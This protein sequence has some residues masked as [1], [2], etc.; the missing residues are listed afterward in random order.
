[1]FR[2]QQQEK[3]ERQLEEKGQQLKEQK[4]QYEQTINMLKKLRLIQ[5]QVSE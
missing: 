1:M 2:R 4:E 5:E 3:Y